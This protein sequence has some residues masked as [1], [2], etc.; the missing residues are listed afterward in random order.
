ME[1]DEV[2]ELCYITPVK[3]VRSICERGILSFS[4]VGHTMHESVADPAVQDRRQRK[5]V[6]C[7][8][9]TDRPL[10]SYVNLYFCARNVQS[11]EKAR[12]PLRR[13]G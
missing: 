10:H 9:G 5:W 11:S 12:G 13:Q 1:P 8:D 4:R 6:P 3:N 7:L 2:R